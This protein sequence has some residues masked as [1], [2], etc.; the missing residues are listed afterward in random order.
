MSIGIFYSSTEMADP[1]LPVACAIVEY[2]TVDGD[3]SK[4]AVID[5]AHPIPGYESGNVRYVALARGGFHVDDVFSG[6]VVPI[7]LMPLDERV[8]FGVM[9]LSFGVQPVQDWGMIC[10]N[11]V[12][13]EKWQ[14]Q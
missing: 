7:F 5:L 3:G 1:N 11:K 13:A 6:G 8:G 9:D 10:L 14:A 4:G 2:L 12:D